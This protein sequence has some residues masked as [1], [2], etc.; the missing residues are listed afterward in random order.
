MSESRTVSTS[1]SALFSSHAVSRKEP[2]MQNPFLLDNFVRPALQSKN[3]AVVL[4]LSELQQRGL[5]ESLRTMCRELDVPIY[6]CRDQNIFRADVAE[7]RRKLLDL[8]IPPGG[9]IF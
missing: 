9:S 8:L 3:D 5:L 1:P 7:F 6:E 4:R 2:E